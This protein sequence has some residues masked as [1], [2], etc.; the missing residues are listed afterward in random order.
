VAPQ[1]LMLMNNPQVREYA[2][3]L[4]KRAADVRT[5]YR[6]ALGRDPTNAETRDAEAF[7]AEQATAY[8]KVARSDARDVAMADFCQSLFCLN[9]FVYLE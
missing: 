6:I 2:K 8:Q 7:I 3:A 9:E 1:A 4:A 5:A